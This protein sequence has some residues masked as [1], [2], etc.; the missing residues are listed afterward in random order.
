MAEALATQ[1][2]KKLT[3]LRHSA[4]QQ[5]HWLRLAREL[6]QTPQRAALEEIQ[7]ELRRRRELLEESLKE[8]TASVCEEL[9][10]KLRRLEGPSQV[11]RG[12]E[13]DDQPVEAV[14]VAVTAAVIEANVGTLPAP[15]TAPAAGLEDA[16]CDGDPSGLKESPMPSVQPLSGPPSSGSTSPRPKARGPPPPKAKAKPKASMA[17]AQAPLPPRSNGLVNINW[18]K[19]AA[20]TPDDFQT[21]D[22]FLGPMAALCSTGP[23]AGA[24]GQL[25]EATSVFGGDQEVPELTETQLQYWFGLRARPHKRPTPSSSRA[26]SVHSTSHDG[27][28]SGSSTPAGQKICPK[29]PPVFSHLRHRLLD[30]RTIRSAGLFLARYRMNLLKR[31]RM[32][33]P[34]K[35]ASEA[36]TLVEEICKAILQCRVRKE[37]D[38][39]QNLRDA[40]DTYAEAGSPLARF[41]KEQGLEALGNCEPE[42]E[43]RLLFEVTRIPQIHERMR[44][45]RIQSSWDKDALK[46]KNDLEVL[47]GGLQVMMERK[48]VL[49]RFFSQAL[50]LGNNLN[51]EAGG[52]V[53]PY[54]FR[55]TSLETFQQTKSPWRPKISLLH[56]VFG[57]MDAD[58]V[59]RLAELQHLDPIRAHGLLGKTSGVHERCRDLVMSLSKLRQLV[60][61][62]ERK[63]DQAPEEDTFH[64]N[65]HSFLQSRT[66]EAI[67]L[68]E[69]CF[70]LYRGYKELAVFFGEPEA[71]YPPPVQSNDEAQDLFLF[72]HRFAE[73]VLRAQKEV[74]SL[75][76]REELEA[77]K[78]YGPEAAAEI[79]EEVCAMQGMP[80]GVIRSLL[81]EPVTKAEAVLMTPPSS[82]GGRVRAVASPCRGGRSPKISASARAVQRLKST[83]NSPEADGQ[84]DVSDW[85]PNTEKRSPGDP[86]TAPSTAKRSSGTGASTSTGG[87]CR[88]VRLRASTSTTRLEVPKRRLALPR[89]RP[90]CSTPSSSASS[91]KFWLDEPEESTSSRCPSRVQAQ[92]SS[93]EGSVKSRAA[94]DFSSEACLLPLPSTPTG[95][96]MPDRGES[97]P[98]RKSGVRRSLSVLVNRLE[99]QAL[100]QF[101]SPKSDAAGMAGRASENESADFH[102]CGSGH[103]SPWRSSVDTDSTDSTWETARS[104]LP[105]PMG[106]EANAALTAELKKEVRKRSMPRE[107]Q[108]P[109][110]QRI[111]LSPVGEP[112][113][114]PFRSQSSQK[115]NAGNAAHAASSDQRSGA[116]ANA[117]PSPAAKPLARRLFAPKP[118]AKPRA[119]PEVRPKVRP[120][121]GAPAAKVLPRWRN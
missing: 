70:D 17:K 64:A 7:Q 21:N 58:E 112:G 46:C 13:G 97:L 8:G 31:Y 108:T 51:E 117:K 39:L 66:P 40:M 54:G 92:D 18:K 27:T 106:P 12:A 89:E 57:L 79:A 99:S 44:C 65:F 19:K 86:S 82:P 74:K 78:M 61:Q 3:G 43:H 67:S 119:A 76:L 38:G 47:H 96:S 88:T 118:R 23:T 101:D 42:A 103:S 30:D 50:R 110:R 113:E 41:V 29:A 53:A 10:A 115:G 11:T 121:A 37:D 56:L 9:Q 52:T 107:L 81:P 93:P 85:E 15:A 75:R 71:F 59:T 22:D 14:E 109:R 33:H 24:D 72:F 63:S 91:P 1:L 35:E 111:N 87:E 28:G 49:Q 90:Q 5:R 77:A 116:A 60:A 80:P 95:R 32:K 48:D 36:K 4:L 94:R 62:V 102:T 2:E 45:F 83:M 25:L 120:K 69:H 55:L 16:P 98:G 84:S 26:T 114:T 68:A 73:A 6:L 20:P 100:S 34:N 104:C 105:Q